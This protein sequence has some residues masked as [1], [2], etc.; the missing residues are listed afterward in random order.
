MSLIHNAR[1]PKSFNSEIWK[2]GYYPDL[3]F[4]SSNISD[5][6][7]KSVM[8]PMP[9]TQHCPICVTVNPVIVQQP[10]TSRRRLNPKKANWDGFSTELDEAIKEVNSIP[11]NY[12]SFIELLSVMSRRHIPIEDVDQ[13]WSLGGVQDP[14]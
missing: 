5:M 2:K 7:E 1:L 10:I 12:R 4:L 3:I 13:T 6:C 11:E 14:L 9:R 8:G